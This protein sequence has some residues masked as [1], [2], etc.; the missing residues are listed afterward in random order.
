MN[1]S[2]ILAQ[3]L[4]VSPKYELRWNDSWGTYER[5]FGEKRKLINLAWRFGNSDNLFKLLPR[6]ILQLI[7][8]Y[9]IDVP[10]WYHIGELVLSAAPK[11]S[12]N[13]TVSHLGTILFIAKYGNIL[14][15]DAV[16]N[17]LLQLFSDYN[18]F[19]SRKMPGILR[20]LRKSSPDIV[21][22]RLGT[23]Q[24]VSYAIDQPNMDLLSAVLETKFIH[25]NMFSQITG[26]DYPPG[27]AACLGRK[28]AAIE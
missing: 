9:D 27:W 3:L 8:Q 10:Y 11:R 18:F 7:Q 20:Q 19:T 16:V 23:L 1:Y 6:E 24:I 21:I 17:A 5:T 25:P 26:W 4:E 14:A 15:K 2:L 22:D 28:F 13:V 12:V